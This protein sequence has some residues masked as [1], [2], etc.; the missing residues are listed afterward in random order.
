MPF[1]GG[2]TDAAEFGKEGIHATTLIG[3]STSF[4]RNEIHYHTQYDT[5]EKIEPEA[6][7]IVFE[8]VVYF[9]SQMDQDITD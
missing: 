5:M 6:V 7:K 8:L 3:L 1:G 9:I 2:A 4:I